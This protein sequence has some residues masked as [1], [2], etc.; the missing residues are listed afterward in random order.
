M[1][2]IIYLKLFHNASDTS[3]V[4]HQG[5]VSGKHLPLSARRQSLVLK[6]I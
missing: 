1:I 3:C 4:T 6:N 2:L 5:E